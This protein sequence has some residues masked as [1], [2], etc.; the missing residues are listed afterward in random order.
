MNTKT[1]I[2]LK[3]LYFNCLS[4]INIPI[5]YLLGRRMKYKRVMENLKD[6]HLGESCFVICNGPSLRPE[7]LDKIHE[8]GYYS[9]GINFISGIYP[10]T[11]WR[12]DMVIRNERT[13]PFRRYLKSKTLP[14]KGVIIKNQRDYFTSL[15]QKGKKIY[16]KIDG[17]RKYLDTPKF[18]TNGTE[19][20]YSVGT[21]TY[22]ALEMAYHL[23]FRKIFIIGCDMSYAVN[24]RKDGTI[25]YNKDGKNYFYEDNNSIPKNVYPNP[26]WE[27]IVALDFV[28]KFSRE[29]GFR[30]YNATRGGCC[31]SFERIDFD[32]LMK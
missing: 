24:M 14:E 1:K 5:F 32:T 28:E 29:N 18:S 11:K 23:G 7:D 10:R 30:V 26:T 12:A 27:Q 31:E 4:M 20:L 6:S 13:L 19:L 22:L 25:Y 21:S 8:K 17:D 15:L 16:V 2:I 3:T 9:I